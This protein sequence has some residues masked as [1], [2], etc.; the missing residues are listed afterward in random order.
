MGNLDRRA[1]LKDSALAAT[2]AATASFP[3]CAAEDA[4]HPSPV[5]AFRP[6][7][8]NRFQA[9]EPPLVQPL[10][11]VSAFTSRIDSGQRYQQLLGFGAPLTGAS[12]YLPEQLNQPL[13]SAILDR[14]FGPFSPAL[15]RHHHRPG[16]LLAQRLQR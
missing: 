6:A 2:S 11:P 16:R 10:P 5:K 9:I 3:A 15:L 4:S 13:V 8:S 1:V 7:E 12:C 14:C